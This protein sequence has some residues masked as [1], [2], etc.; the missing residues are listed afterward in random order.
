MTNALFDGYRYGLLARKPIYFAHYVG[1][2][3]EPYPIWRKRRA[4]VGLAVSLTVLFYLGMELLMIFV[5][6]TV[7]SHK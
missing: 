5:S 2:G 7:T 3:I 6:F 4:L 1:S